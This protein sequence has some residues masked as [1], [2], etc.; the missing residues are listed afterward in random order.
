MASCNVIKF[1]DLDIVYTDISNASPD[2]AI[3]VFDE[4]QRIISKM[5]HTSRCMHL[6][7]RKM[8]DLIQV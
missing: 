8:P 2:E 3:A 6:Y 4:N 1:K 5:P 7:M